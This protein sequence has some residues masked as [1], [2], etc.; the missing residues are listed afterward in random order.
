MTPQNDAQ[1]DVHTLQFYTAREA[2]RTLAARAVLLTLIFGMLAGNMALTWQAHADMITNVNQARLAQV[3]LAEQS[4]ERIASLEAQIE[5]LR[6]A[7]QA[8]VVPAP[9]AALAAN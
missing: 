6:V 2:R 7:Q 9:E 4:A 1:F 5:A 8:A 3:T